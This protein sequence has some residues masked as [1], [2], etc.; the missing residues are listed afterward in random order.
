MPNKGWVHFEGGEG[1]GKIKHPCLRRGEG[2]KKGNDEITGDLFDYFNVSLVG[3][4]KN[5]SS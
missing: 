5:T 1:L 3:D 2:I 4:I